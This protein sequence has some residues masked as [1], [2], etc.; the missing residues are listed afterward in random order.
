M[1]QKGVGDEPGTPIA[2]AT[3][4][5]AAWVAGYTDRS[6]SRCRKSAEAYLQE[7]EEMEHANETLM[8]R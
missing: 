1:V 7:S 3:H 5:D 2:G 6:S 8:K 4:G